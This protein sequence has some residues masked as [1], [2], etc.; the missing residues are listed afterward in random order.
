MSPNPMN[1]TITDH[2]T[3]RH[4][5]RRLGGTRLVPDATY[6]PILALKRYRSWLGAGPYCSDPVPS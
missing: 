2:G 4:R 3:H 6:S 1:T 5:G